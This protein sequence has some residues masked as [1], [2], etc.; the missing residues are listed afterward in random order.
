MIRFKYNEKYGVL[1]PSGFFE[2]QPIE[3][4]QE[5]LL[6]HLKNFEVNRYQDFI[7]KLKKEIKTIEKQYFC[8][9]QG[10]SLFIAVKEANKS[11]RGKIY[12]KFEN[13]LIEKTMRDMLNIHDDSEE[14]VV[15]I[16]NAENK[17]NF[18][19]ALPIIE[20]I[21]CYANLTGNDIVVYAKHKKRKSDGGFREYLA[22][23][24]DIIK[25][26]QELN[27]ILQSA[28]DYKNEKF[29]VAY[30]LGKSI[31]DN[32]KIH[33]NN[34]YIFKGDLK[35]FFPSCTR[36]LVEAKVEFLFKNAYNKDLIE[37]MFLDIALY[38]NSLFIG[39]PISGSLANAIIAAPVRYMHNI[40]NKFNIPLTVYADD[41]TVSSSSFLKKEFVEK[42]FKDAFAKYGLDT[43][44]KLKEAKG[45]GASGCRRR[46]TGVVINDS[47]KM[48]VKRKY[49]R[50]LRVQLHKLSLG[51]DNINIQK[52]RG[53][54][55]FASM[56]DESGKILRLLEKYPDVVSEHNLC[57]EKTLETLRSR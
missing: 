24:T 6:K 15:I 14:G 40:F 23:H 35:D 52:L 50:T 44:F 13:D 53:Q 12:Y 21:L 16:A 25:P 7:L 3:Q 45:Y 37:K 18:I 55:A 31:V 32:A 39:N 34:K 28:Y 1:S 10:H 29:Q 11:P 51:N 17:Y 19:V 30:K 22:P 4:D 42:I 49:Y 33:K 56:L 2:F 46:I 54:L 41:L 8:F 57:S 27:K 20:V 48:T 26:F 43:K 47:N 5:L 9:I 38:N 36:D